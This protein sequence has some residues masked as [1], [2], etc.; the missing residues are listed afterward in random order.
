MIYLP[1]VDEDRLKTAWPTSLVVDW[2]FSM[3]KFGKGLM[4]TF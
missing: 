3:S 4:E 1:G 2:I